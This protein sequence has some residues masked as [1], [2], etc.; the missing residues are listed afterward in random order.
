MVHQGS[1]HG[2][3][4]WPGTGFNSG[5]L[6]APESYVQSVPSQI[7][8]KDRRVFVAMVSLLDE[9]VNN[10]TQLFIQHGLWDNT[11]CAFLS[12]NGSPHDTRGTSGNLPLRGQ[13]HELYEGGIRVPAFVRGPG[14]PRGS[15]TTHLMAH[16]DVYPTLVT[17]AGGSIVQ[18]LPLDGVD[19]WSTILGGKASRSELLHNYDI[20]TKLVKNFQGALRMDEYKLIKFGAD[21][22]QHA[23]MDTEELYNVINDPY[24]RVNLRYNTTVADVF[25]KM[26]KRLND[27]KLEVVPCWCDESSPNP[28][29]CAGKGYSGNCEVNKPKCA[30]SETP[31]AY[32]PGWCS[33][34][35]EE[36]PL[37]LLLA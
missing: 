2:A 23:E 31:S 12:D 14:V 34:S 35:V 37:E 19:Q 13:K 9:A 30:G 4:S 11:V 3:L 10:V 7:T 21:G 17:L 8:D 22:Q 20:S 16:I 27:L 29:V 33:P 26:R 36:S 18:P 28:G 1:G 25:K 5:E 24:E 15:T 32:L 6:Q